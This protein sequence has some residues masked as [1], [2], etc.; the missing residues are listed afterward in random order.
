VELHDGE[1]KHA[2]GVGTGNDLLLFVAQR[3]SS[4]APDGQHPL[5]CGREAHFWAL[6]AALGVLVAG[7]AFSL[8]EGISELI[9]PS[10]TSS[11]GI[12]YGV[13]ATSAVFDLVS[14][15]RSAGQ[16]AVRGRR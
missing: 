15:R 2:D 14:I 5:G 7:A 9:H 1:R 12:A 13:L 8:R 6:I 16:M 3:R 10:A 4:H 11:F